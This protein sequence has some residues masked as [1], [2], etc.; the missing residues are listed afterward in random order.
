VKRKYEELESDIDEDESEEEVETPSH[1]RKLDFRQQPT[2]KRSSGPPK[3]QE[4][5][6][7]EAIAAMV[8]KS[9][10]NMSPPDTR[11]M[12]CD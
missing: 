2:A 9:S 8:G 5:L 11:Y 12:R 7:K 6:D 3:S 4:D 1:R 10:H